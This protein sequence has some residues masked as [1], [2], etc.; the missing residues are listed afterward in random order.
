[1]KT[2]FY[3]HPEKGLCL[4]ISDFASNDLNRMG[5]SNMTNTIIRNPNAIAIEIR[6]DNKIAAIK[7][8]RTQTGW[9]LKEAKEYMDRYMPQPRP[10]FNP[11]EVADNFIID[12]TV[13]LNDFLDSKD[14]QI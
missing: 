4:L 12:H 9:S 8:L 7:E 2:E 5:L 6:N 11:Q 10:F 13:V 14:M 1:M 3:I